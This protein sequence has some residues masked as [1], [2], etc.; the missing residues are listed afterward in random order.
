MANITNN[1]LTTKDFQAMTLNEQSV[2]AKEDD[3]V[4]NTEGNDSVELI[5]QSS[6]MI[7]TIDPVLTYQTTSKRDQSPNITSSTLLNIQ[8][9]S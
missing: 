3:E 9:L 4:N 7:K 2:V 6:H 1:D 8:N 5:M